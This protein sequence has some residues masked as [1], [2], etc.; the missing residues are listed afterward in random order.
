MELT[1][2]QAGRISR[3]ISCRGFSVDRKA[4]YRIFLKHLNNWDE[5]ILDKCEELTVR[6]FM[7]KTTTRQ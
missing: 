2:M 1:I 4:F 7:R 6:V 5:R 3:A